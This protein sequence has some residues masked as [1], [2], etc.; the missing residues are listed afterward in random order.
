MS[1][2]D[3]AEESTAL[4]IS[5]L[6][7]G[8]LPAAEVADTCRVLR[9]DA[10]SRANWHAYSL[11][12]DVLRSADLAQSPA[13]DQAFLGA[14]R[15]RLALE[16]VVLAP[17]P[18]EPARRPR[19]ITPLGIAAGVALVAGLAWTLR[20]PAPEPVSQMAGATP[21]QATVQVHVE[22]VAVLAPD[23]R[24]QLEPYL[25]AHR[26]VPAKA[27]FGPTPGFMRSVAQEPTAR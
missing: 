10:Q 7:D 22:T 23:T 6:M 21:P 25:N 16:P 12:G 5:A 14:L 26:M 27:A 13:R 17:T 9:T 3:R 20:P 8:E 18:P 24:Q 19:W 4:R 2:S 11:I 1:E 15:E